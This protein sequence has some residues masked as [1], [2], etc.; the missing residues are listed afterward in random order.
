MNHANRTFRQT[1]GY[2]ILFV[3]MWLLAGLW[4]NATAGDHYYVA[5]TGDD[6][7]TGLDSTNAWANPQRPCTTNAFGAGDT[8]EIYPG[9]YDV[10]P[11]PNS[12]YNSIN[13]GM[14][15]EN[16]GNIAN[17]F[18]V[19][20]GSPGLARPVLEF[21]TTSGSPMRASYM[22]SK[23]SIKFERLIFRQARGGIM[24]R[25]E[26]DAIYIDSC[27]FYDINIPSGQWDGA[28]NSFLLGNLGFG[29]VDFRFTG[30]HMWDI[31]V[32]GTIADQAAGIMGQA[33]ENSIFRGNKIHD[34]FYGIYMKGPSSANDTMDVVVVDSNTIY[35]LKGDGIFICDGQY[36]Y[37]IDI[38]YNLIYNVGRIFNRNAIILNFNTGITW[39]GN[40]KIYNNTIDAIW[41]VADSVLFSGSY[42]HSAG[43][44]G[45]RYIQ[46]LDSVQIFNNLV[47][48]HAERHNHG[49][50]D[51]A[52]GVLK[53]F[54]ADG[55][56]S[57]YC[58]YNYC[59]DTLSEDSTLWAYDTMTATGGGWS[60]V[61]ADWIT[62]WSGYT[63]ANGANSTLIG[64][65]DWSS[66]FTDWANRN[67]TLASA[68]VGPATGG[69]GAPWA[70]Y[71]GYDAPPAAAVATTN[72][73]LILLGS[74]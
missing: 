63:Y 15:P 30:N 54:V 19:F 69:R 35:D 42:W 41:P 74:E 68:S 40:I 32:N 49:Y 21:D 52:I 1:I 58:D 51:N 53:Q 60:M 67:Y 12:S 3:L 38:S 71:M 47:V 31:T 16:E 62:E 72:R 65:G 4:N 61:L 43:G 55:I 73:R 11:S 46:E 57:F 66:P 70:T 13:D 29:G 27:D 5:V 50:N 8:V 10:N 23:D 18:I 34:T 2:M 28:I 39:G 36:A 59:I 14:A 44:I 64:G 9:T 7:N 22:I 26:C 56:D 45:V 24:V 6:T 48:D 33:C 17:G 20:M 37:D 25:A